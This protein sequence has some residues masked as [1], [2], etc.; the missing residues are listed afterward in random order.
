MK[1]FIR[2]LNNYISAIEIAFLKKS[3]KF[4]FAEHNRASYTV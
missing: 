3:E 1:Y 2:N 4:V